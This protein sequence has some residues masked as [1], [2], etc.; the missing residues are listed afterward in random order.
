M[1]RNQRAD[2]LDFLLTADYVVKLSTTAVLNGV[3]NRDYIV[4]HEA[5]PKAVTE[6]VARFDMVSLRPE[7]LLIPVE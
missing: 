7:G 4:V 5:P 2:V 6:L 1:T 3:V